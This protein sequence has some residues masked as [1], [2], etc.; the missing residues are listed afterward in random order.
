MVRFDLI[1]RERKELMKNKD[2][3]SACLSSL[4]LF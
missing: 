1:I 4:V 3:P 2:L